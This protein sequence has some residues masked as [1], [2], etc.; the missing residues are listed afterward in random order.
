M[1]SFLTGSLMRLVH[2]HTD[3]VDGSFRY[4]RLKK[5]WFYIRDGFLEGLKNNTPR[6]VDDI[7]VKRILKESVV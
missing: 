5:N 2:I 7:C 3:L 4:E 6:G 1:G